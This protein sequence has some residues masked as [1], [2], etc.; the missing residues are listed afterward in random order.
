M[1]RRMIPL[2][3]IGRPIAFQRSFR[4]ISGST[5]AALFL[6]QAWY[7][8]GKLPNDREGWF[9]KDQDEWESETGLSRREQTTARKH[10][11]EVGLILEE[12][13]GL[14]PTLW[15]CID[16]DVLAQLLQGTLPD[17]ATVHQVDDEP[18]ISQVTNA[19]SPQYTEITTETTSDIIIGHSDKSNTSRQSKPKSE[20]TTE[21]MAQFESWYQI[22]PRKVKRADA[23]KAWNDLN[24]SEDL[25][26][27][28]TA[29]V[30]E[31]TGSDSWIEERFIPHPSTWINGKRWTDGPP[32]RH[33]NGSSNG[34][35][36]GEK[37][38][39][40]G[41]T[42]SERGWREHPGPK[43]WSADEMWKRAMASE[44]EDAGLERL[45]R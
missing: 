23:E 20:M 36:Y 5:V 2:E 9:F 32:P 33:S 34:A 1:I 12:R 29:K 17:G 25:I 37:V 42:D 24:P 10:L 44:R 19:P 21:Q 13:R 30:Q 39:S 18:Y 26:Q 43:G 31:W 6:S 7:W 16:Q 15:Y 11:K 40:D 8:T 38:G 27:K 14:D 28:M 4:A 41:L 22:Y 35:Q 45:G 3:A